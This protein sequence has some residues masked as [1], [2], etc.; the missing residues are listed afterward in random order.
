MKVNGLK[1]LVFLL[2]QFKHF[3]LAFLVDNMCKNENNSEVNFTTPY[4]RVYRCFS[5]KNIPYL[6]QSFT[7]NGHSYWLGQK[8]FFRNI[9]PWLST[10]VGTRNSVTKQH[11]CKV[12]CHLIMPTYNSNC[13]S[14][15][16]HH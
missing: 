16:C 8:L 9:Y 1:H 3:S 11:S 4:T 14:S 6:I 2:F 5:P 13:G 12:R 10:T 15:N 7:S